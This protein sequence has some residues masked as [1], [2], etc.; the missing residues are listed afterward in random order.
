[1]RRPLTTGAA[2]AALLGGTLTAG[3]AVEARDDG[4]LPQWRADAPASQHAFYFS[5]GVYSSWS[6]GW[7]RGNSWSTDYPKADNQFNIV[8]R[9]LT[10][11]D[12]YPAE[13]A[14][15]FDDPALR[16]YPFL[17]I[18]EVGR[19]ALTPEEAK[20]LRNY[21]LAGGF[22]MVDD[23]WGDGQ[24]YNFAENMRMVL[25]EY[26][27]VDIPLDHEFF[28]A[29]Y[30][31]E[32]V[33]QVPNINNARWGQTSE[34]AG[35]YPVVRGIFDDEGRL[36]VAINWNTDLGDAW[37]WAEQPDYPVKYSTYAFQVGVN[38]IIYAMS[39]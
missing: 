36:M 30:D 2:A 20:G 16:R 13:H 23:F 4:P 32:A 38:T 12:A 21:L 5:R 39:H 17:Y 8:L 19:M 18:L 1:M 22:L 3:M 34:C 33:I 6:R 37:E 9:R 15:G 29:F 28:S 11:I 24:W 31:V 27:I 26:P 14:I 25:P 35:C 7:G 10:N